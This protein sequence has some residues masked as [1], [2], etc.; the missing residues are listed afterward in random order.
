MDVSHNQ[1]KQ[2][3]AGSEK[4]KKH[5]LQFFVYLKFKSG[6]NKCMVREAGTA[7]TSLAKE[8]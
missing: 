4:K 3:K 1:T 7:E 5:I 2:V 8:H 6:Q